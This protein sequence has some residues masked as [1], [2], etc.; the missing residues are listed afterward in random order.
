MNP[1]RRRGDL[2]PPAAGEPADLCRRLRADLDH[3]AGVT[4]LHVYGAADAYT[5]PRWLRIIGIA[6][7]EAAD[8]G[9]LVVDL[10]SA[11]FIGCRPIL[12]L[13]SRAPRAASRGVQISVFNPFPDVVDRV[14]AIAGLSAWLPVYTTLAQALTAGR[15]PATPVH[16]IVP[17]PGSR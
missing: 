8:S 3:R 4:L 15:P 7:A 2:F 6:I 14:I 1:S 9:H 13:A 17:T 10:S 12:D 16:V 5:E 11:R